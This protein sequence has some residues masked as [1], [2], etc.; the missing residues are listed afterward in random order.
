MYVEKKK[1]IEKDEIY[2]MY[3]DRKKIKIDK[4]MDEFGGFDRKI[5]NGM[6]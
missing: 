5:L 1:Y 2:S 3:G 6:C 4:S